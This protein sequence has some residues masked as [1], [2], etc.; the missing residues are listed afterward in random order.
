MRARCL[1]RICALAPADVYDRS[2]FWSV[3]LCNVEGL[4][5]GAFLWWQ[6]HILVVL[7]RD[8]WWVFR[9]ICKQMSRVWVA[10]H[11]G[12]WSLTNQT[13]GKHNQESQMVKEGEKLL[14]IK[15]KKTSGGKHEWQKQSS[16][17]IYSSS[18]N[19][20]GTYNSP[21]RFL[22]ISSLVWDAV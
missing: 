15:S 14:E 3:L 17:A 2:A 12:Y 9:G 5:Q 1:S 21:S 20:E 7:V 4:E 10:C 8:N 19:L 6:G 16:K 22:G 13:H 18:S 11:W